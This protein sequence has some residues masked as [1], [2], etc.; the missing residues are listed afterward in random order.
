[1]YLL[2]VRSMLRKRNV[3][4]VKDISEQLSTE[5]AVLCNFVKTSLIYTIT[6]HHKPSNSHS[7]IPESFKFEILSAD[8]FD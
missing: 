8:I 7:D 4:S 5:G 3:S 2:A 6:S 1:M